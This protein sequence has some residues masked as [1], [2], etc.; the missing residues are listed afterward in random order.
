MHLN[1]VHDKHECNLS[2]SALIGV[3]CQVYCHGSSDTFRL[4]DNSA[5]GGGAGPTVVV[6]A[7]ACV[8]LLQGLYLQ[9]KLLY[10]GGGAK[11]TQRT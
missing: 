4:I 3:N 8:G 9:I 1:V 10:A 11:K 6:A 2:C 7:A 5:F